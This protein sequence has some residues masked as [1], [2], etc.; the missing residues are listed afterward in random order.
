MLRALLSR[1][2]RLHPRHFHLSKTHLSTT[3]HL[4]FLR[5]VGIFAHV[6]AGKTTLTEN[7]L[8][9][10][11]VVSNPG[12]VD[13]GTTVTDFLPAERERGITIQ[14]ACISFGWGGPDKSDTKINLI[15]TPGHVDFS[16]E[17]SRSVAVLDGAVLV[18]DGVEGVQAQTET[19]WNAM[20]R[21]GVAGNLREEVD[22]PLNPIPCVGCV[23][24]LDRVGSNFYS[25]VSTLNKKLKR[26]NTTAANAIPIQMPLIKCE[27]TNEVVAGYPEPVEGEFVG[28][29]DLVSDPMRMIVWED[30]GKGKRPG[31][32][33]GEVEGFIGERAEEA[34][35]EMIE[36]LAEVDEEIEEHYLEETV[37]PQSTIIK[38]LRNS[39]I[40]NKAMPVVAAAALKRKGIEPI[41]DS[42]C[43]FLPSPLDVQSPSVHSSSPETSSKRV[44][45][46]KSSKKSKKE[47]DYPLG[48]PLNSSLL[49][50]AFKVVHV[51]GRGGG[52]GRVVFARV[53]S[54]E[55]ESRKTLKAINAEGSDDKVE[56]PSALLELKG[57]KMTM[58]EDG[59]ARCGEVCAIVGLKKVETGDTLV[60]S[61]DPATRGVR[62][63]GVSAPKPVLTVKLE[64]RGSE[65]EK[66][67]EDALRIL[68]VEDPSLKVETGDAADESGMGG[69][70]GILLSGLGELHVEVVCDRLIREFNCDVKVGEPAVAL[71]EALTVGTVLGGEELINFEREIAGNRIQAAVNLRLELI[72]A[73]SDSDNMEGQTIL[74]DNSIVLT[75]E[76]KSWL[77][78]D[79]DS[80]IIDEGDEEEDEHN[81]VENKCAT[82]LISGIKG[83]LQRGPKGNELTNVRCTV[84]EVSTENGYG[85]DQAGAIRAAAN[86]AIQ[87][88]LKNSSSSDA[89]VLEPQM[90][91]TVNVHNDYI[92]NVLSDFTTRG[93]VISEVY[94][95]ND[96][97]KQVMVGKVPL[98][99]ILGYSTKLRSLTA[100]SGVFAAEYCAHS[101]H[102]NV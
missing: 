77:Q 37:P 40:N 95:V 71:K 99:S 13:S 16:V 69:G 43:S 59:V 19:V 70:S 1:L 36:M 3:S 48:H 83:A 89:V 65:D 50:L 49:A 24:K 64:A 33:V 46:K 45:K 11:D 30:Q 86:F 57:G 58:L 78:L 85:D 76:A 34:R 28:V 35:M 31:L 102:R 27:L 2:P 29:V 7:F 94:S 93:G 66:K 51:K 14:S 81:A 8:D 68:C 55:L 15:D 54:G 92:G 75:D 12:M 98:K 82:A 6:D 47:S 88:L 41:L 97:E 18:V 63:N 42:I 21:M 25:A 74:A 20:Q 91:L 22:A 4:P 17:I 67:L 53:F 101:E 87:K 39:T 73:D 52:D 5:N 84:L 44:K 9:V 26:Q 61:G 72:S 32:K 80:E 56:R 23:N 62:L 79:F 10:S 96:S 38:S 100:G 90:T 60:L